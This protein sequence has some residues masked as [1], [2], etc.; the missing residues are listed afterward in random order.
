MKTIKMMGWIGGALLFSTAAYG[1]S[2][3][4]AWSVESHTGVE[5]PYEYPTNA[6]HV[7]PKVA[8]KLDPN[9]GEPVVMTGFNL[10]DGKIQVYVKNTSKH[11]KQTVVVCWKQFDKDDAVIKKTCRATEENA[12]DSGDTTDSIADFDKDDRTVR[13]NIFVDSK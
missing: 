12:V 1:S 4:G 5:I 8:V 11:T 10:S 6:Q 13:V 9:K 7:E 3:L 2:Q